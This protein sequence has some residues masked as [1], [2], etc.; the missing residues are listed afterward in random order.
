MHTAEL[1]AP[2][3][4]ASDAEIAIGN[5]KSYKSSVVDRIP[6]ELV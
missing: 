3:P 1:Y 6:L 2:K 5:L 4:S